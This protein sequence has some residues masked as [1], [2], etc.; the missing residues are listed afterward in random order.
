MAGGRHSSPDSGRSIGFYAVGG[1]VAVAVIATGVVVFKATQSD[2]CESVDEYSLAADPAIAPAVT[3][4]L[5]E[6]SPEQTGCSRITVTSALPGDVAGTLGKGVDA[7][8]M[9]VPDS[10]AWVGKAALTAKGPVAA[11]GGS[12]ATSPVV[13]ASGGGE[14]FASWLAALQVPDLALGNPLFTGVAS[15]PIL[16]ALAETGATSESVRAALVPHAQAESVRTE[17]QPVGQKMLTELVSSGKVGVS[18]EQQVVEFT[19]AESKISATVPATGTMIMDYPLVVSASA[20]DRHYAAAKKSDAIAELLHSESAQEVLTR[21][22]FRTSGGG[23]VEGGVGDVTALT[24]SEQSVA[25][26]TLGAWALMA[27][28][29][30]TLVAID[31]S[32]SMDYPAAGGKT[33]MQLTTAA[34]LAGNQVFPDSVAAGLWAFSQGMNG[35]Q[36]FQE[37]VPIRRYDTI[38]DGVTQRKLMADQANRLTELKRGATGLYDTTLAAFR[39][40]QESYDPR[41]VNSVIILTD[42]ANE[43]PDSISREQLLDVLAREQDPARPVII[44]TIGITDDADAAALAD[45]SRV[46]GG[47]TYIARD[48]SEISEVFVNA[49]AHRG[50]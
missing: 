47:S 34:A 30:R 46:T 31:V 18:T 42:G 13:L 4:I 12:I 11:A 1:L 22:G 32:A 38:V 36:D 19:K 21:S 26:Q 37:L 3:E 28:P 44:V 10:T 5:A 7:P 2:S 15:A 41:A 6:S 14:Q 40:V 35:T 33:R 23:A 16:G 39:K 48:P 49:L 43:D 45:I 8:D 20:P 27:K 50:T 29:I 17:D 24:V 25:D 9:W